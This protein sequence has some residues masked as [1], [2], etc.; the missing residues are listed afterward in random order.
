[1]AETPHSQCRGP[2]FDTWLRNQIPHDA[3]KSSRVAAERYSMPRRRLMILHVVTNIQCSKIHEQAN[4]Y[5][6]P[7]YRI[8]SSETFVIMALNQQVQYKREQD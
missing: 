3:A 6:T 8:V 2:R 5:K 4:K 1:M 7:S